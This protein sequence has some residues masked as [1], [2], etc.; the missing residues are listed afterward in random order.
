MTKTLSGYF[1]FMF[2]MGMPTSSILTASPWTVLQLH[3]N[4]KVSFLGIV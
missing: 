3:V 2:S 1:L 4:D